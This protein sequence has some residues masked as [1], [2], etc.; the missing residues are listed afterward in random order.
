MSGII[1]DYTYDIFISYRQKDNKGDRWV[2]QFIE[3]LRIE[4]ESTVKEELS[5]YFDN[6]PG[7][8]ILETY[9]VDESLKEKLKCLIFIPV[10]SKTY[11][12]P[13][14]FAWEHEFKAFVGQASRDQFGLK[15][16][17]PNGNVASRVLPVKIHEPDSSDIRLC[18]SVL[19]GA[20]RGVDFIFKSPGINRPLRINEDHPHDNLNNIYYRDQM[21]KLAN[22][23]DEIVTSL[24]TIQNSSQKEN[25][26]IVEST[27]KNIGLTGKKNASWKNQFSSTNFR[28]LQRYLYPFLFIALMVFLILG[29][30][31]QI[32]F[33]GFGKS[34]RDLAK[35]YVSEAVKYFDS[36]DYLSAKASADRALSFDP[37]YSYAWST[38][39]A[40]SV[41]NGDL[42]NAILQ[43]I[44][45]V[46][47]DP[48][49]VTAAYNMAIALDDRKDFHQAT[50]WY[51]KAIKI[52]SSFVPAYSALGRLYN[53]L[54]QPVDAILILSRA[55]EKNSG[56]EYLYLIYRN[57]GNSHLLLNQPDEAIQNLE[58]SM[59]LKPL[60]PETNLYLARAYETA[61]KIT[62]SIDTWQNY[63][64][65]ETDTLKIKDAKRHLREITVR[66]LQDILK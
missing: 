20:L 51:E 26:K 32:G 63:I 45:A 14:S 38:L 24:K 57:L 34:K 58:R 50:E 18:E 53:I 25:W 54:N 16:P 33:P 39:A 11:C 31:G 15:I 21:N 30:K 59:E 28:K 40:V 37:G 65:S 2:S 6:N 56:S 42:N 48:K 7:D 19:G 35:T 41:K 44:E 43:T 9:D 36:K 4:L 10:I 8:G 5:V 12:D 1:P 17:L 27:T 49:N 60:E 29:R 52:D 13:K 62:K 64:N 61:G 66:H 46:K 3:A 23:I 55:L 47:F 22:A